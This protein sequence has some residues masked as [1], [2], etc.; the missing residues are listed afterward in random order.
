M[1]TEEKTAGKA[2]EMSELGIIKTTFYKV[3]KEYEKDFNMSIL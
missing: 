2:K 1:K 3:V